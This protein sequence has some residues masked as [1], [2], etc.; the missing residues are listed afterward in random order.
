MSWKSIEMQVALPRTLDAG[1][2]Q[3]QLS[4]QNQQFQ[5]ALTKNQ[6][7]ENEL[8]RNR[9]NESEEIIYAKVNDD[10]NSTEDSSE[11]EQEEREEKKEEELPKHPY[12][13]SKIDFSG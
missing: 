4:K 2:M 8:K 13:G 12:L 11:R 7:R 10:K 9:V 5:Q 1:R 6:V 3:E